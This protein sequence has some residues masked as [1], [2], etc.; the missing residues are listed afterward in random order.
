M[1]LGSKLCVPRFHSVAQLEEN[2]RR[3]RHLLEEAS[4]RKHSYEE[5]PESNPQWGWMEMALIFQHNGDAGNIPPTG[6]SNSLI[7]GSSAQWTVTLARFPRATTYDV[8]KHDC[9]LS[10]VARLGFHRYDSRDT[11]RLLHLKAN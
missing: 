5:I 1:I 6:V 7:N 3:R 10:H 2:Q 9:Q 8:G 4:N 11:S